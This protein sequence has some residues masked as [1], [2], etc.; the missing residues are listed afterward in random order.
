MALL[1]IHKYFNHDGVLKP[2]DDFISS[3]N[4]GGIYEVIRVIRAV[5]LFWE[6]HLKRFFYSAKMAQIQLNY[7][8]EEIVDILQQLIHQN[9]VQNGNIL[10]SFK[11]CLKAFFIPHN[12]PSDVDYG[13]GVSCGVLRAERTN[14]NAKVFQ[15]SVRQ[16][17]N[18]L[19]AANN[20]YEVVLVD[21]HGL[22]TEGSRSNLFF[23]KEEQIFTPRANKVLLG[24]TRQKTM[25]CAAELDI[26][27][28]ESDVALSGLS[29]FE[30]AFVTGTSPKILPIH[31]IQEIK[32]DP[33][34]EILQKLIRQFNL[35]IENYIQRSKNGL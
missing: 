22:I 6:E 20:Y 31:S 26:S 30:A 17:A 29:N 3:E 32:F 18:E 28:K 23:I 19:I 35:K 16:K 4:D 10:V 12:Y 7:S 27:V 11:N 25:E 9:E 33:N 21:K 1:P 34:N 5:P 24:I 14:P 15:T 8:E 2:I 13:N